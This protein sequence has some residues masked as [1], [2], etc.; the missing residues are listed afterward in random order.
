MPNHYVKN[1]SLSYLQYHTLPLMST[2]KEGL[3]CGFQVRVAVR[4]CGVRAYV[5]MCACH[6]QDV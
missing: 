3:L 4:A 2:V 1:E 6:S 5:R